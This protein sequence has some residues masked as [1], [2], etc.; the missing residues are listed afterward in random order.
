MHGF[1]V[2]DARND[3]DNAQRSNVSHC[4]N[5]GS[6]EHLVR[7][8]RY[9]KVLQHEESHGVLVRGVSSATAYSYNGA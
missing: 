1:N 5:R 3:R 7:P 4:I 2:S 9:S 6:E 8:F